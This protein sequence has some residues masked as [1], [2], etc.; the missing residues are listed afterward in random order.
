LY[1]SR[2][3]EASVLSG[4][5]MAE[6]LFAVFRVT[7]LLFFLRNDLGQGSSHLVELPCEFLELG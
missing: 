1:A 3:G 6:T 5:Y 4:Q 7:L 2:G